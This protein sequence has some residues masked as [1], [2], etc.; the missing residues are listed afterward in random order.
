MF[1]KKPTVKSLAPLRSSDR[2][3]LADQVIKDYGLDSKLVPI[4]DDQTPEQKAEATAVQSNLRKSL[5]PENL[6]SARFTNTYGPD[7]KQASG[8][9]YVGSHDGEEPRVLWFQME[10]VVYPTVYTLWAN[11][12]IVPLLHTPGI[13]VKKLQT[14]ADLMTPGLFGGPPFPEKARK[15]AVVAIASLENPSVPVA[16]GQCEIDVSALQAVRGAKGHAV[17]NLHWFGDEVW[18]FSTDGKPGRTAPEEIAGWVKV[19]EVRGLIEN[20]SGLSLED[21][22]EGGGASLEDQATGDDAAAAES[23]EAAATNDDDEI[24]DFTQK[25]IDEAFRKAFLFG[26]HQHKTSNSSQPN[27][28]LVFPLSQSSVMST[29]IQPFLPAHTP[30]QAQQLQIKKTSWKNIKKFIKTLDKEGILKSKEKD[31][32]ETVI[33]DVKFDHPA[34]VD[35]RP[36]RLPK[37]ETAGGASQ[38]RGETATTKIDVGDDSVGQKLKIVSYFKPTSKLQPIFEAASKTFY[39]QPEVREAVTAYIEGENLV[40]ET[41]KRIVKLDPILANAVFTGSGPADK[42]VIAK[43]SVQRDTLIE[44]VQG[45]MATSYAIVR[46]GT[47]PS[48]IKARSGSPPKIHITLETRS[49]NKTVTKVSGLEAY[50]INP[51][52]LAD[53]LRKVCAGSTSVEPLAGAAKKTEAQVMEIMVQGPQQAAVVKALEKRGVDKR[54]MDVVDKTKGK[55]R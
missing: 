44:R 54:W 36:Y 29:L 21:Q 34:I 42:A 26:I 2:R 40:S 27:F 51:K 8:T 32:R 9:L 10:G 31:G 4:T 18:S 49:G 20:L 39:T 6:Q 41:N 33:S 30:K 55:K 14:G 48:S 16:V 52:Q 13:V 19:L 45:A 22:D 15:G 50:H 1:K 53:E 3:K 43:G 7:L 35:F 24:P 11:T 47:D 12:D 23:G 17:K 28:G 38:G 5:F 37:K 46:N 25:E